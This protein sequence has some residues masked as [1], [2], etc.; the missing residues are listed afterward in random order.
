M[1]GSFRLLSERTTA[2]GWG[3]PPHP[4]SRNSYK[5]NLG[6]KPRYFVLRQMCSHQSY[7]VYAEGFRHR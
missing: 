6:V 1:V 7:Y 5:K 4:P 3:P 2:G